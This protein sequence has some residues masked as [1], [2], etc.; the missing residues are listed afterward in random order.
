MGQSREGP[1][2]PAGRPEDTLPKLLLSDYQNWGNDHL[3]LR[4]KQYGIWQGYTW[5]DCYERTKA[6]CLGLTS[7]GL[8]HGEN[9]CILGDSNPEWFW[10]E[11]AG[12]VSLTS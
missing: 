3:A 2:R 5:K 11:L 10:S 4:K 9:A 1:A 6:I 8:G 7:L 12:G